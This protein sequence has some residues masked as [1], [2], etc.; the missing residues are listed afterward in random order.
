MVETVKRSGART[1]ELELTAYPCWKIGF[2][3]C[4]GQ[5]D[6]LNGAGPGRF[7]GQFYTGRA[8]DDVSETQDLAFREPVGVGGLAIARG[9]GCRWEIV[10]ETIV[11]DPTGSA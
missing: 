5:R 3:K 11:D 8:S 10:H 9:R 6:K 1:F 2:R 4:T 7:D